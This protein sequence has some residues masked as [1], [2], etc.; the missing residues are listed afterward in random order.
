MIYFF[1]S[2]RKSDKLSHPI[3]VSTSSERR[4]FAMALVNFKK[5]GLKGSPVLVAI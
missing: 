4:A 3:T 5:N 1:K 2:S